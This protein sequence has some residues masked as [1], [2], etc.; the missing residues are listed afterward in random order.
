MAQ[1]QVTLYQEIW[2][3]LGIGYGSSHCHQSC[4]PDLIHSLPP[5]LHFYIISLPPFTLSL[6][7]LAAP[8]G[9]ILQMVLAGQPTPFHH[10]PP[11]CDI[12]V[13]YPSYGI[14]DILPVAHM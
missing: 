5:S 4:P 13:T 6:E 11:S 3:N 14:F 10:K 2:P 9:A 1:V 8:E 7:C 12:F